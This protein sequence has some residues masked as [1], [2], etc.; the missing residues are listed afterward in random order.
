MSLERYEVERLTDELPTISR[1]QSPA[2]V[3]IDANGYYWRCWG[4]D[5]MWSMVPTNPDNSP[6]PQPVRFFKLVPLAGQSD[7]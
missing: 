5:P 7:G 2:C 3:A 1:R 4:E 6:I